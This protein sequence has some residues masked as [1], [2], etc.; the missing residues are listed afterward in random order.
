MHQSKSHP[1]LPRR[2]GVPKSSLLG[3]LGQDKAPICRPRASLPLST[4]CPLLLKRKA[5]R[6]EGKRKEG[7][8]REGKKKRGEEKKRKEKK[9]KEK[10]RSIL[11][12]E[13]FVLK[14]AGE[15]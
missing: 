7:K 5:K 13:T 3:S 11:P 6:R 12:L 10:K 8:G 4:C 14:L 9:R 15:C 1:L 2:P